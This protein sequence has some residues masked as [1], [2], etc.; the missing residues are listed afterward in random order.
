MHFIHHYIYY[1]FYL[2]FHSIICLLFK[3]QGIKQTNKSIFSIHFFLQNNFFCCKIWYDTCSWTFSFNIYFFCID[4]LIDK[5]E[6]NWKRENRNRHFDA[7]AIKVFTKISSKYSHHGWYCEDN[8][9]QCWMRKYSQWEYTR[10]T[11]P[12]SLYA[13]NGS[14]REISFKEISSTLLFNIFLEKNWLFGLIKLANF[15]LN[16]SVA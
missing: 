12:R 3:C 14:T 16:D 8:T 5:D 7:S 4:W 13:K 2:F 10:Q 1:D 9:R 6:Q 15:G 11:M